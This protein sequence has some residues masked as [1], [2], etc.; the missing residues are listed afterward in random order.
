MHL[1]DVC[2]GSMS[3]INRDETPE[4]IG[5]NKV[6]LCHGGLIAEERDL[7]LCPG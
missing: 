5:L 6:P 3:M 7:Q 1:W 2:A 4:N